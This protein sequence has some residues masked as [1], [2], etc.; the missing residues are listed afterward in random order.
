MY[1]CGRNSK[2][3]FGRVFASTMCVQMHV[4]LVTHVKITWE[5]GREGERER[6]REREG[7]IVD[8]HFSGYALATE[9]ALFGRVYTVHLFR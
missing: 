7:P 1:V 4:L 3:K 5:G 8:S 9:E 6:E 2:I